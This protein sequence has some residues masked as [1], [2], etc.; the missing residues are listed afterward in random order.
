MSYIQLSHDLNKIAKSYL[1]F[2]LDDNPGIKI[3]VVDNKSS[4]II[5]FRL[6]LIY[7]FKAINF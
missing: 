4:G 5:L 1:D 3:L 2:I 6:Y 7:L